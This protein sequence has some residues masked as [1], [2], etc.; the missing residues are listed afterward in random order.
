MDDIRRKTPMPE[1]DPALRITGLKKSRWDTM[2]I[3]LPVKPRGVWTAGI[4]PAWPDALSESISRDSSVRS[5]TGIRGVH[6]RHS[7]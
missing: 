2:R 7:N 4:G 5:K 6:I 3:W 1:L